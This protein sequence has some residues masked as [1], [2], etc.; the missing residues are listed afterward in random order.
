VV[1][2]IIGGIGFLGAGSIIR[3]A[4]NVEGLTTAGSIWLVGA[5]GIAAGVGEYLLA[6]TAVVLA[7]IVLA[8]L[9]RFEKRWERKVND[10]S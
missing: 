5:V 8:A 9:G 3:N 4:G 7:L 6:C 10:E 2:G 1:E